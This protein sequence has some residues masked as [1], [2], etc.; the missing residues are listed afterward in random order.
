MAY[1]H[2][3]FYKYVDALLWDEWDPIGVNQMLDARDE[4]YAYL[5]KVV[6]MALSKVDSE[7]IAHHL[8]NIETEHMGLAGDINKCRRVAEKIYLFKFE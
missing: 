3:D 4:Y 8:L 1:E 2:V 6:E 7:T 5:P